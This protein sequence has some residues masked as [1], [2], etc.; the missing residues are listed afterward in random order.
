MNEKLEFILESESVK[1]FE[2]IDYNRNEKLGVVHLKKFNN[3]NLSRISFAST[4]RGAYFYLV[5]FVVDGKTSGCLMSDDS[6]N[7]KP[8]IKD[9]FKEKD[10]KSGIDFY[11]NRGIEYFN[12]RFRYEKDKILI[13]K[14]ESSEQK[15]IDAKSL[16]KV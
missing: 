1:T 11:H 15:Y 6:F 10:E 12:S 14:D 13:F 2:V 4:S 7:P 8:I 3:S 9:Y 16:K 5:E